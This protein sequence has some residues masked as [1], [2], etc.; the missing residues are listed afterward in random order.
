MNYF[1]QKE[2]KATV[3]EYLSNVKKWPKNISSNLPNRHEHQITLNPVPPVI[4]QKLQATPNLHK[5]QDR[6]F[7]PTLSR[8]LDWELRRY[9]TERKSGVGDLQIYEVT[10]DLQEKFWPTSEKQE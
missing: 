10:Y 2:D 4:L 6:W 1:E 9:R 8:W 5:Q 7:H 3:F